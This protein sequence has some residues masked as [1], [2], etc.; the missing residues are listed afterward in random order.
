MF[1]VFVDGG[2]GGARARPTARG[3]YAASSIEGETDMQR[4]NVKV[5]M[6]RRS[7]PLRAVV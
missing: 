4:N 1:I 5:I 3:S 2:G 7:S 6:G